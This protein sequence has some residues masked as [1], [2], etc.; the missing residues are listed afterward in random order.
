[1]IR[2]SLNIADFSLRLV[3]LF[4]PLFSFVIAAYVRFG[5]GLIPLTTYDIDAA[6]YFGLLLFA[7]IVWAIAIEHNGL[8]RIDIVFQKRQTARTAFLERLP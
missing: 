4:L 6:D 7:T 3:T 8:Y 5:S 1:M 2:R